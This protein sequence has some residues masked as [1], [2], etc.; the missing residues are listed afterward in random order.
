MF[1]RKQIKI[2]HF[3]TL[4]EHLELNKPTEN[5]QIEKRVWNKWNC[6][7]DFFFLDV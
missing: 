4:N 6:E 5:F 7:L 3:A 1:A 2:K